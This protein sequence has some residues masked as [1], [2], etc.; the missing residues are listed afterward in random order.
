MASVLN[1]LTY[2]WEMSALNDG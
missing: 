2:I 1:V